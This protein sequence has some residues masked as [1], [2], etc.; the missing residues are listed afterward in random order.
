MFDQQS[1]FSARLSVAIMLVLS[2]CFY[3]LLRGVGTIPQP[4]VTPTPTPTIVPP[5]ALPTSTATFTPV[6]VVEPTATATPEPAH[7][8]NA[9]AKYPELVKRVDKALESLEV[10]FQQPI[11]NDSDTG[12]L[13]PWKLKHF[14]PPVLTKV[15]GATIDVPS[16]LVLQDCGMDCSFRNEGTNISYTPQYQ[17]ILIFNIHPV[18]SDVSTGIVKFGVTNGQVEILDSQLPEGEY[19]FSMQGFYHSHAYSQETAWMPWHTLQVR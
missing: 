13:F 18:G 11:R 1:N 12:W 7:H 2:L 3:L 8:A 5:T 14:T 15:K 10:E 16:K 19:E 6:P 17:L 4:V 9:R